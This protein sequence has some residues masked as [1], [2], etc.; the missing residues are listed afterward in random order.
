MYISYGKNRTKFIS[1]VL[2]SC[3]T[4]TGTRVI[5]IWRLKIVFH[6][7]H[8]RLKSFFFCWP[9]ILTEWLCHFDML[10]TEIFFQKSEI[11]FQYI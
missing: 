1:H 2:I 6:S 9:M 11:F 8:L 4:L 10:R 5:I 3:S 7:L